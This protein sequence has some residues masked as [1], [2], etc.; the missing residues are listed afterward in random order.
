MLNTKGTHYRRD[1]LDRRA[2][3]AQLLV[4]AD[5]QLGQQ[6]ERPCDAV[7]SYS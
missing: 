1:W 7:T 6:E 4:V 3:N 5:D 2:S